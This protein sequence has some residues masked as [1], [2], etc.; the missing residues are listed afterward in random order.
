MGEALTILLCLA[1]VAL[2]IWGLDWVDR[3]FRQ[4]EA[5]ERAAN[6]LPWGEVVELPR[7]AIIGGPAKR[8][9]GTG[10]E[11][12]APTEPP[13]THHITHVLPHGRGDR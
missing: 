8:S 12:G 9:R 13:K 4:I 5:E 10:E 7:E 2:A 3:V 1:L 11:V 6:A